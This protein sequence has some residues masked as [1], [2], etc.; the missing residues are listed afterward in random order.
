MYGKSTICK[1]DSQQEFAVC[2]R[3]LNIVLCDFLEE[4]DGLGEGRK[5]QE[6][7]HM[8]VV[9]LLRHV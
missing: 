9:Q 7:G 6:R 4:W 8:Y 2:L 5:V 1:I 3:N